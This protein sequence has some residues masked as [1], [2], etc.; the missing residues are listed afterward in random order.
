MSSL[1]KELVCL[2]A[3]LSQDSILQQL[4]VVTSSTIVRCRSCRTYINPFVSFLDQ[5]RW[6]CNLCYRVNDGKKCH[7]VLKTCSR[8]PSL[9]VYACVQFQR[10][11]CTTQS[12][13]RM[14]NRTKDPKSRTPLSNS[15]LLQNTWWVTGPG[16]CMLIS[17]V[18]YNWL[19]IESCVCPD[20]VQLRPPQPAV[21]LFVLDVSHNALETGYLNVFCQSLLDNIN[22]YVQH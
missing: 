10:N 20:F 1:N 17:E 14:E 13:D 9:S 7:D 3:L 19:C 18:S 16:T 15:L 11:S 4:P 12:A 6:K 2:K 8:S 22:A 5:R 21:Y